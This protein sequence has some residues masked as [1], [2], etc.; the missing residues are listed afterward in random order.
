MDNFQNIFYY[1][2]IKIILILKF[3]DSYFVNFIALCKYTYDL[4]LSYRLAL[5][6]ALIGLFTSTFVRYMVDCKN[7]ALTVNFMIFTFLLMYNKQIVTLIEPYVKNIIFIGLT[8]IMLSIY[9]WIIHKYIMH[10]NKQSFFYYLISLIDPNNLFEEICDHHIEHHKEVRPNMS[11]LKVQHK[12]SLFMGWHICM[13]V[14]ALVFISMG[15]SK[16]ISQ[17]DIPYTNIAYASI[18]FSI[19]WSYLWNKVHPLM[20]LYDGSYSLHEGPYE[21]VINFNLINKLFY[22]NHQYHHLQKGST[23][24]NYNVIVFGA[25]EWFGTNVKKIDNQSYCS[26]PQVAHE[27][28]CAR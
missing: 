24:G 20:H 7:K 18:G 11:L 26:N 3:N 28:I 10:C 9:E 25:D 27:E 19:L 5:G 21:S 17:L 15:I 4:T 14:F 13:Y 16:F 22:R 8:Y 6:I 2:L 1:L 12:T 23:K